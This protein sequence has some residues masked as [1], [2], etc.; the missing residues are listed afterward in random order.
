MQVHWDL[1]KVD[2]EIIRPRL[3]Q[4]TFGSL[5]T[6]KAFAN[7]SEN[8]YLSKSTQGPMNSEPRLS[9]TAN[10]GISGQNPGPGT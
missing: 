9:R 8:Q 2:L 5:T 7:H 3:L 4:Q 10:L 1:I 6:S